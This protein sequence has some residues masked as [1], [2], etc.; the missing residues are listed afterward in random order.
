M[1]LEQYS[2]KTPRSN[3]VSS[4]REIE[5]QRS[6]EIRTAEAESELDQRKEARERN[7][8]VQET[9]E[10]RSSEERQ[11]EKR[12]KDSQHERY[13]IEEQER[14]TR[15]TR[16]TSD[17][18]T[19]KEDNDK[20]RENVDNPPVPVPRRST[21]QKRPPDRYGD[22]VTYQMV[23]PVDS[24]VT[25]LDTLIKSGVFCDLDQEAMN[26]VLSAVIK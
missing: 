9:Q 10:S 3:T 14:Q 1:W 24:R 20:D 22:V 7:I 6:R 23:R 4:G 2:H 11:F 5:Q 25:K 8:T 19:R 21:R 13:D 12:V 18:N 17:I 26:I 16:D 15:T